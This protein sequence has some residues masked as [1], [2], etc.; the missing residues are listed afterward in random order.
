M[1]AAR[2][3]NGLK[4]S[5]NGALR[6]FEIHATVISK[7]KNHVRHILLPSTLKGKQPLFLKLF[8]FFFLLKPQRQHQPPT[9]SSDKSRETHVKSG[10]KC[11]R[12]S[13]Q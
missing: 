2:K 3:E 6:R 4:K 9:I 11:Q 10:G 8:S 13:S 7:D 1:H 5:H 12:H